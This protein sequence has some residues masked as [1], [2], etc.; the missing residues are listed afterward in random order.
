MTMDR[1]KPPRNRDQE[2]PPRTGETIESTVTPERGEE[3]RKRS[4]EDRK[5]ND[6]MPE[7]ET[8]ERE[9]QDQHPRCP[10]GSPSEKDNSGVERDCHSGFR[11]P[12]GAADGPP[13]P[14]GWHRQTK[15]SNAM[16]HEP[17]AWSE[18]RDPTDHP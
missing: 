1:R 17:G 4:E 18:P 2:V 3:G 14:G 5:R 9:A 16:P 12:Y 11:Q 15:V 8:Y 7:E 10:R 13:S 6:S